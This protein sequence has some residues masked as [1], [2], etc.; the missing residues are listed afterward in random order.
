MKDKEI[1]DI[2][3]EV[4]KTTLDISKMLQILL[5]NLF[6]TEKEIDDEPTEKFTN[7]QHNLT[8]E[9]EDLQNKFNRSYLG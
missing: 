6:D 8:F 3:K 2:L 1:L 5:Y 7:G 9:E 4:K